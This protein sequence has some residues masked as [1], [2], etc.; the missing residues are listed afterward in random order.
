MYNSQA[1]SDTEAAKQEKI[2]QEMN[3]EFEKEGEELKEKSTHVSIYKWFLDACKKVFYLK[4]M[5]FRD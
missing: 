5:Y 1:V 4:A 3:V 2:R